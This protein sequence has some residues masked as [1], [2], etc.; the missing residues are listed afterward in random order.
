MTR[1]FALLLTLLAAPAAAAQTDADLQSLY[2]GF[3]ADRG[4][5]SFVDADGDVQFDAD[6]RTYFIGTNDYDPGFFNVVMLD[7]W[8]V[9]SV[10]ERVTALNA[11]NEVGKQLKV[12]KGYVTDGDDV[13][14]ACELFL[15]APGDFAPV[16]DECLSTLETAVETFADAM[17]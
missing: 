1:T 7:V 3:L 9:E 15:E 11:L 2:T 10:T 8:P 17:D 4:L 16:F 13:W 6:G 12:V 14:L 5:E